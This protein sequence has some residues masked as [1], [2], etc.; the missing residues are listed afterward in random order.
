MLVAVLIT[1]WFTGTIGLLLLIAW[2]ARRQAE[3][4]R[5]ELLWE[6]PPD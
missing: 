3:P 6:E 5:V 4:P 1:L 2:R